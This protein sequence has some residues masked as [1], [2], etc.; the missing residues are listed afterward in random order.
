[1][2]LHFFDL[3]VLI[4]VGYFVFNGLRHG[5]VEEAF[6]LVGLIVAIILAI[7]FMTPG[8][9][10][11]GDIFNANADK[12]GFVSFLV[13]FVLTML[14]FR[15]VAK[16]LKNILKFAMLGWLDRLGG[17]AFGA[18]KG[19]LLISALI[20][21]LLFLPVDSYTNN[22]REN[23]MSFRPL[24][25]FAPQVYNGLRKMIPNSQPFQDKIDRFI[26]R[27]HTLKAMNVFKNPKFLKDLQDQIGNE[28][29]SDLLKQ[30]NSEHPDKA[31]I[32]EAVQ[33]LPETTQEKVKELIE[34]YQSKT[35]DDTTGSL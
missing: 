22:L 27:D 13:I 26:S 31:S 30:I 12:L 14:A 5:L 10:L 7:K 1:M 24:E 25:N 28:K 18:A 17:G 16:I 20:W 3:I 8:A 23:S 32:Q 29:T 33:K 35:G 4:I 2:N 15:L 21:V 34:R 9:V 19:A 6:K 11:L